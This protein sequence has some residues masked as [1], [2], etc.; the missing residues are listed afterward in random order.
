[1]G[2]SP[3]VF[4]KPAMTLAGG[5][6]G[7]IDAAAGAGAATVGWATAGRGAAGSAA[8][9]AGFGA[10]GAAGAA[11][12]PTG[13]APPRRT[14]PSGQCGAVVSGRDA[15]WDRS[16]RARAAGALWPSG[17]PPAEHCLDTRPRGTDAS[18]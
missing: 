3:V 13:V 16:C 5:L 12:P 18:G 4:R 9:A 8:G 7:A 15:V 2:A 17:D 10:A 1:M 14:P 6:S 11:Q